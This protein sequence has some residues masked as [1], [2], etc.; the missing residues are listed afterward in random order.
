MLISKFD[1]YNPEWLELVFED[2]N[3]AYGAY[4]LRLHHNRT[5]GVAMAI[6]FSTVALL[7]AAGMVFHSGSNSIVPHVQ[8]ITL[9][10]APPPA[11]AIKKP[12][13]PA[14]V[15]TLKATPA[16]PPVNTIRNV[17]PVV[18]DDS[19]AQDPVKNIDL[20]HAAS[21][22]VTAKGAP[23]TSE[24]LDLPPGPAAA[25][26]PSPETV[27]STAGLDVM[28][29][30]VGGDAAWAKFLNRN[31]RYP[32]QAQ[33]D[34][35]GGRVYMSFIVEKDGTLSNINVERPAGHGFDEE[36]ARVLKLAKA[37]KPGMQ[38]GQAVRVKYIIPINF[39]INDQP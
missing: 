8:V 24:P 37:W 14:P 38:N 20:E 13:P 32:P 19:H 18:V 33:E 10:L 4:D 28:P 16:A 35:V 29:Q 31:L 34:G 15:K 5:M 39:Q 17:P 26:A 22:Q 30:P 23:G 7:V 2:R 36:A 11:A 27:Y 21:G 25:P 6:T 1:L 3:K 12:D 9:T